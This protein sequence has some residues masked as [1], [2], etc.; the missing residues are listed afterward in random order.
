MPIMPATIVRMTIIPITTSM[1]P[2]ASETELV[3]LPV[4]AVLLAWTTQLPKAS[5][6]MP[7]I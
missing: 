1:A 4:P 7:T 6:S 3:V 2:P 5:E